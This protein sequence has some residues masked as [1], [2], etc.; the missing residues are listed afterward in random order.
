MDGTI[1][2]LVLKERF[3]AST[4]AALVIENRDMIGLK[5]LLDQSQVVKIRSGATAKIYFDAYKKQGFD[6]IVSFIESVPT[7]SSGVVSYTVKLVMKRPEGVE[8]YDAM[9]ATA[10]IYLDSVDDAIRVPLAAIQEDTDGKFVQLYDG[11]RLRKQVVTL[12]KSDTIHTQV[13]TGLKE[14]DKVSIT[15]YATTTAQRSSNPLQS[16]FG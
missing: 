6:A 2:S 14:G 8:L 13:L 11:K 16:L 7:E 3:T 4:S 5:A 9:T 1:S 15:A 10:Q 12:G